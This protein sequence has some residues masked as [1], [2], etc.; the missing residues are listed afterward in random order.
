M[1]TKFTTLR[2]DVGNGHS[3][4]LDGNSK[5]TGKDGTFAEPS[6]NALSYPA[7]NACPMSTP[8]CRESCY[9]IGLHKHNPDMADKYTHNLQTLANLLQTPREA[10]RAAEELAAYI[11]RLHGFRWH[12]SGD[13]TS[14]LHA[15]WISLVCHFTHTP[16]WIYTRS[17]WWVRHLRAPTLA[18]NISADR[19]NYTDALHVAAIT[20]NR[21]CYMST[22]VADVPADLPAGS[23]IFP[24][25]PARGRDSA[26]P[27]AHPWW[28][29]R[30]P[31]QRKMVCPADFFGQSET[32]RCGI[33]TKCMK[34]TT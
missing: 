3:F 8:T 7:P 17:L 12:V 2:L 4:W 21:V 1:K 6:P 20:G 29:A 13:V 11:D 25:Y 27:L 23:V 18:V 30:T 31:E 19:D 34:G 5:I 9:T 14:E 15:K 28:L 22:G 33:C 24:D 16:S 10:G 32:N 26:D